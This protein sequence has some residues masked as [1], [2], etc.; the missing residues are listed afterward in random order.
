MS[1]VSLFR[2]YSSAELVSE[3]SEYADVLVKYDRGETNYA[4]DEGNPLPREQA[5][6]AITAINAVLRERGLL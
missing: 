4:G 3:R 5:E 2:G 1:A 6:T